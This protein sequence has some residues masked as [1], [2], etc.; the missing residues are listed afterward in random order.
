MADDGTQLSLEIAY[1]DGKKLLAIEDP[2]C[3][4]IL[5]DGSWQLND[6]TLTLFNYLKALLPASVSAKMKD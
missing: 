2:A 5:V 6:R 4:D 1:A 3:S